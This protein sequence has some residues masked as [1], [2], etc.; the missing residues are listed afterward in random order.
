MMGY[1]QRNDGQPV[2]AQERRVEQV[3]SPFGAV[4]L[5]FVRVEFCQA[6]ILS[7]TSLASEF[8]IFFARDRN[9]QGLTKFLH[10]KVTDHVLSLRCNHKVGE[11]FAADRVDA[12]PV[13]GIHFH[14]GVDIQECSV[15]FYQN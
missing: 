7:K 9:K 6:M 8:V 12:R 11:G 5:F 14:D 2:A 10:A 15:A 3:D 1:V 13:G 4:S